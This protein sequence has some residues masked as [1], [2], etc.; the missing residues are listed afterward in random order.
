[1]K[2][3]LPQMII[4]LIIF[5]VIIDLYTFKGIYLLSKGWFISI[6]TI[7]FAIYWIFTL[8]FVGVLI[9]L[10]YTPEPDRVPGAFNVY[11]TF[12]GLFMMIYIPKMVFVFFHLLEDIAAVATWA[13][14][15][16]KP[17]FTGG[18]K[19]TGGIT[20]LQFLS[21]TGLILS[22]IPFFS[23]LYGMVRG[24][25]Q[26]Q[27]EKVSLTFDDLPP[28][29]EG[30]RIVQISDI[31]L[32]SLHGHKNEIEEAIELL[33]RQKPDIVLFTGDM[34]NNYTE[35]MQGWLPVFSKINARIGKFASLG[36]HDYGDYYEWETKEAKENNLQNLKKNISAMG[37]RLLLNEAETISLK[38]EF[39]DILGV[40]NWGLPPFKQYGDLKK[41]LA[42]SK[43]HFRI[44]LSHDP[45]H[46]DEQVREMSDIQLTLSGH[47]HGMQFG[48]NLGNIKWSPV[49]Y[50]YPR[51]A[52]LY[53]E[54]KQH[55]Y[56]NRGF[57]YIGYPGR[58]G[59][60]PE[61]TLF[62]LHRS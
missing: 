4:S 6:Q 12:F 22:A 13:F 35:E 1:M 46:W 49:K 34:V 43:N 27:V 23:V 38:G 57:G 5:I 45:T 2:S 39:I 21:R 56:V 52:G 28:S 48:I 25:F 44:L 19:P 17:L 31:H 9:Y 61:I 51:W 30:L 58:V 32:G 14:H 7:V 54:G 47:T 50:K 10:R 24:R 55:L 18:E 3:R 20:R 62:E 29:F 11:F 60:L 15:S 8:A 16:L 53:T 40:E 42:Q 26:F 33:N 41:T 37:F 59:M 36:N